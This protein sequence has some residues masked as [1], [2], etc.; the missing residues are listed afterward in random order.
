MQVKMFLVTS[1]YKVEDRPNQQ[2]LT[3]FYSTMMFEKLKIIFE[4]SN[5]AET[6]QKKYS[7]FQNL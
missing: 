2:I 7:S 5:K 6:A 4:D 1:V 3:T